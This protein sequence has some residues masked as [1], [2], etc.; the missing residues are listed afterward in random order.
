MLATDGARDHKRLC[1]Q[2]FPLLIA[3][4][5]G[6]RS[7][8]LDDAHTSR[9]GWDSPRAGLTL[10]RPLRAKVSLCRPPPPRPSRPT[11]R[12]SPWFGTRG[13]PDGP[14]GFR[15]GGSTRLSNWQAAVLLRSRRTALRALAQLHNGQHDAGLVPLLSAGGGAPRGS[16]SRARHS[17]PAERWMRCDRRA[18]GVCKVPR[19]LL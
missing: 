6:A 14:V 4:A 17:P 10:C 19:P 13:A 7:Q 18:C 5:N 8:K 1:P 9:E 12:R 15:R 16:K 3:Q 2:H 11:C